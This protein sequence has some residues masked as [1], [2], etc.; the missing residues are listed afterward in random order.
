MRSKQCGELGLW[1]LCAHS[2]HLCGVDLH[3]H[4]VHFW[5]RFQG[6]PGEMLSSSRGTGKRQEVS[7]GRSGSCA[8]VGTRTT[9]GR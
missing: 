9:T 2:V 1:T 5:C 8:R 7:R 6:L 4:S 3:T